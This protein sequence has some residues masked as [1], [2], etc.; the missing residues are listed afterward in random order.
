MREG[1][2]KKRSYLYRNFVLRFRAALVRARGSGFF[3][4]SISTSGSLPAVFI[5]S[6]SLHLSIWAV[7]G[8]SHG[9]RTI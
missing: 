5:A 2:D 4:Y 9:M 8:P 7:S 1:S 3:G 6:S